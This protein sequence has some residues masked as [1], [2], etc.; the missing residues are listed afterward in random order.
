MTLA[1]SSS[2][3]DPANSSSFESQISANGR[4]V[5]FGSY[6]SNLVP[7]DGNG[8][9]A[10]IFVKDLVTG[11][12]RLVSNAQDGSPGNDAAFE[13]AISADGTWVVFTSDA[14]NLL[15]GDGNSDGGTQP[16]D[17]FVRNLLTGDLTLVTHDDVGIG[18]YFRPA[19]SADGRYAAFD[20]LNGAYVPGDVNGQFD[21]FRVDLHNGPQGNVRTQVVHDPQ[22]GAILVLTG[23]AGDNGIRLAS[24]TPG[25]V[26]VEGRFG[27]TIDGVA[28]SVTFVGIDA[29][30]I[31]LGSGDDSVLADQ[32]WV[33][34]G[35]DVVLGGGDDSLAVGGGALG[36]LAVDAGDGM[37]AVYLASATVRGATE[38]RLGRGDDVLTVVDSIFAGDAIADGG[39]DHDV[40]TLLG[41]PVFLRKW[42]R[43]RFERV[44]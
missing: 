8:H 2:E 23:D 9:I 29:I 42:H 16:T 5:T 17:V 15:P 40:L 44:W 34:G 14:G 31:E 25:E 28:A 11:A 6:A 26:L 36:S 35:L 18:S 10:D 19:I 43:I 7:I 22:L 27:T 33:C 38:I 13:S 32:L 21:V 39:L 24:S 20:A 12:V 37:D 1:S 4:Y 3:G 30:R 41:D